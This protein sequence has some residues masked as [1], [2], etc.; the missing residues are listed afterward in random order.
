MP[1][2]SGGAAARSRPRAGVSE[3]GADERAPGLRDRF[4]GAL[5]G[6]VVG[7]AL[8]APFEGHPGPVPA[9]HLGRLDDGGGTLRYS[10]DTALTFALGESLLLRGGLDLDH[11]ATAFATTYEREPDR[12]YGAGT[13][14]VLRRVAAGADWRRTAAAQF[15][16]AGSFGNGAAMR[17]APVALHAWGTTA[18]AAELGRASAVVTHTHPEAVDAAGVQAVAVTMALT[19]SS[20][21]PRHLLDTVAASATTAPLGAALAALSRLAPDRS[22]AAVAALTGTGVAAVEAVPAAIAVVALN[23][24]SF[25]D[26]V[27]FAIGLG[28]DTDTIA[29]MVGAI[30]GARLG[31]GAV[32]ETWRDRVEGVGEAVDLADRLAARAIG[33]GAPSRG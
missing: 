27:R 16:G 18:D 17:V 4:R 23:P 26:A 14:Q 2:F 32:P 7:D 31:E 1:A 33:G 24:D 30:S 29:A 3:P 8:G 12:G 19:D 6:A 5:V 11:L 9:E 20:P 15:G 10:D 13:A 28:G 25:P 21:W 22:P